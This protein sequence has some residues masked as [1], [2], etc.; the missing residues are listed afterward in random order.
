VDDSDLDLLLD[1]FTFEPNAWDL[2]MGIGIGVDLETDR[3]ALDELADAMLVWAKGARFERLTDDAIERIWDDE[4][5]GMVREG[6]VR[7]SA[8]GD[9]ERAAGAA[10]VEFDRDPR[11]SDVSRE[12]VRHLAMQ[13]GQTDHPPFFCL[14]CVE[15]GLSAAESESKREHALRVAIVAARSAKVPESELRAALVGAIR[16]PPVERL[17]SVARRRAVRERLRRIGDLATE[18][19]PAL[20]A[21]LKAIAAEPLPERAVDDDVWQ[22]A[23]VHLLEEVGHPELN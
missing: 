8:K 18:S 23:C 11:R 4:L 20:A 6:L 13:L 2:A 14:C 1:E 19:M 7:L 16:R 5:G 21:E 9:W 10:L 22:E 3:P 15:D 17:A 12:V